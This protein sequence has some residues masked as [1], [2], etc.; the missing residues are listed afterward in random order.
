M[1]L[2]VYTK[3]CGKNVSG[4]MQ[5]V[6]LNEIANLTSVTLTSS[7][8]SDVTVGSAFQMVAAEIDSVQFKSEGTGASNYFETQTLTIR[9]AKASK[10]LNVLIDALSDAIT[11][12]I[13]AIRIDGN[14]K[15]WMSGYDHSAADQKAR[16]YNQMKVTYDSGLKPSDEG[17]NAVTIELTRESEW[18]EIPFT[19]TTSGY[20]A[21]KSA[22]ATWCAYT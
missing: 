4:N 3:T 10:E 22:S 18:D 13:V 20:M 1:A 15:A 12:G 2:A 9:F 5:N 17:G 19:D 7:E 11:C 21:I 14:G 16:P 8:I 6:F